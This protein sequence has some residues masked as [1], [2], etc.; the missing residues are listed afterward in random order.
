[1]LVTEANLFRHGE[2]ESGKVD[3]Q[4]TNPRRETELRGYGPGQVLPIDLAIRGDLFDAHWRRQLVV[5]KARRINDAHAIQVSEPELS[6]FRFSHYRSV[7]VGRVIADLHTVRI[8][9]KGRG[10]LPLRVRSPRLQL[11]PMNAG[12]P[13]LHV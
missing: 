3:F 4:I 6:V 7:A 9:E 5:G 11:R 8:V 2:A 12:Q 1:E 10:N 13:A